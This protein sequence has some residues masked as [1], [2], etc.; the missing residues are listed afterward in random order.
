MVIYG[1]VKLVYKMLIRT[2]RFP[3]NFLIVFQES[4]TVFSVE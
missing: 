2:L 4:N 3:D 1:L